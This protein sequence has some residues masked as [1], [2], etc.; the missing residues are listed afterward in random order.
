MNIDKLFP[1][2]Y[3][4]AVDLNTEEV[5][6]TISRF[7]VEPVRDPNTGKDEDQP[8]IYT[9]EF[10]KPLILNFTNA[11]TIAALY[12]RETDAWPGRSLMLFVERDF[13]AFGKVQDVIRIRNSVPKAQDEEGG[14]F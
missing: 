10:N 6:A 14:P 3:L 9:E 2:K 1:S 12:G 7:A 13:L 8:L 5:V 11:G 4:K